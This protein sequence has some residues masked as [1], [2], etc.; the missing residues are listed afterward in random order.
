MLQELRRRTPAT[1]SGWDCPL[2]TFIYPVLIPARCP[3]MFP[4]KP[5]K[6]AWWNGFPSGFLLCSFYVPSISHW[7]SGWPKKSPNFAFTTKMVF[8][9]SLKFVNSGSKSSTRIGFEHV[10]HL[11]RASKSF[12]SS[13]PSMQPLP[14]RSWTR[15]EQPGAQRNGNTPWHMRTKGKEVE[16]IYTVCIYTYIHV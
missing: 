15:A 8:P 1:I 14:S 9:K 10:A 7:L 2:L 12:S 16:Y 13:R 11:P 6:L 5:N 4:V 3:F